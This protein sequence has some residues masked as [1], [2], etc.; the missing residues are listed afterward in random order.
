MGRTQRQ[1]IS[2]CRG[3]I[4]CQ[5]SGR[6]KM[7]FKG[8]CPNGG[9]GSAGEQMRGQALLLPGNSTVGPISV[10]IGAVV[11]GALPPGA[12]LAPNTLRLDDKDWRG[13]FRNRGRPPYSS[14]YL[15]LERT[16]FL[17][18]AFPDDERFLLRTYV[19]F[20]VLFNFAGAFLTRRYPTKS[21]ILLVG[22]ALLGFKLDRALANLVVATTFALYFGVLAA[23]LAIVAAI[24][25]KRGRAVAAALVASKADLSDTDTTP[26][27][28]VA[29]EALATEHS[30]QFEPPD[31]DHLVT[32]SFRGRL[33]QTDPLPLR[34]VPCTGPQ[35]GHFPCG[36]VVCSTSVNHIWVMCGRVIQS[37]APLSPASKRAR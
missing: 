18:G 16:A 9:Q 26:S 37:S 23:C 27:A 33:I 31:R 8:R 19:V 1:A 36:V 11:V 17:T 32:T 3:A 25:E 30:W 4:G 35:G 20:L 21:A 22:S 6:R 12:V 24:R 15:G 5:S 14:A 13:D 28:D 34:A 7:R 10:M 29:D 2:H